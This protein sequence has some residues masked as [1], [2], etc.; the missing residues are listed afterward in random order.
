MT[1]LT[2]V[3]HAPEAAVVAVTIEQ[4]ATIGRPVATSRIEWS[5]AAL[6]RIARI[7]EA[8]RDRSLG[9]EA[10]PQDLFRGTRVTRDLTREVFVSFSLALVI[11]SL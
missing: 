9:T 11:S 1:G 5:A 3:G 6:K 2:V 7:A 8:S 4:A 10:H